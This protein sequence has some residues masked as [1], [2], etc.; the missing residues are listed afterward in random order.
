[1]L[2]KNTDDYLA[3]HHGLLPRMEMNA[4]LNR[5]ELS[6]PFTINGLSIDDDFPFLPGRFIFL[7]VGTLCAHLHAMPCLH[8]F[9]CLIG[10]PFVTV[11]HITEVIVQR[12]KVAS[13][14]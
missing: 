2:V 5:R 1:M 7:R 13:N 4:V 11:E 8:L 10:L 12:A 9:G 3:I 14:L 6:V